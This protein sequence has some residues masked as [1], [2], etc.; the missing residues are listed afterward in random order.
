MKS[1]IW[2]LLG[3]ICLSEFTFVFWVSYRL[4]IWLFMSEMPYGT[5]SSSM[6]WRVLYVMQCAETAE[7]GTLGAAADT[8]SC[9][10]ALRGTELHTSQFPRHLVDLLRWD[11]ITTSFFSV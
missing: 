4:G 3:I 9:I 5:L 7:P 8:R 1:C 2:L 11:F 10:Q 6:L